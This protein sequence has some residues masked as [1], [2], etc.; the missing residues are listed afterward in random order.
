MNIA[1]ANNITEGILEYIT[2]NVLYTMNNYSKGAVLAL[3]LSL[4]LPGAAFAK[5]DHMNPAF[6]GFIQ[7]LG[8]NSFVLQTKDRN[9][10][11]IS[12]TDTTTIT[13]KGS[14]ITFSNL[15]V[16]EHVTVLG[17][18]D[19]TQHI[20]TATKIVVAADKINVLTGTVS[21]INGGTL[22]IVARGT[23]YKVDATNAKTVRR[24][25]ASMKLSDI[26]IGDIVQVKGVMQTSTSI[27]ATDVRD[28]SLQARHGQFNG[29][30]QSISGTSFVITTE[31]KGTQ[32]INTTSSTMYK[33]L[34]K[35]AAFTDIAVGSRL[36]VY[37]VWNTTNKNVTAKL[38]VIR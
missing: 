29:T 24:F 15:L 26:Q 37:G 5:E 14:S 27:T 34:G 25:N 1:I 33:H 17:S 36:R 19:K 2:I 28:L 20:V 8:T 9:Q 18:W 35:T 21:G 7:S 16:G 4:G 12:M 23:T 6:T 11:T 30:V 3:L 38:I 32:T 31:H 13:Q 10:Q 22:T